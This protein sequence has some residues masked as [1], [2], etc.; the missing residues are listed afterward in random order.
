MAIA[1]EVI[2]WTPDSEV[3]LAQL[4]YKGDIDFALVP[5]RAFQT[6]GSS[7]VDSLI[8]PFLG[9]LTGTRECRDRQ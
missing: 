4:V 2:P 6:L 5:S 9:R 3:R 1:W 8:T 7:A